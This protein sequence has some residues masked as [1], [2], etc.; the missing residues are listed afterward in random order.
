MQ[1]LLKSKIFI[2][3]IIFVLVLFSFISISS[4]S[5]ITYQDE[6][7]ELPEFL[8][9][10]YYFIY[11]KRISTSGDR[12]S[13]AY[14]YYISQVP[15][16]YKVYDDNRIQLIGEND[17]SNGKTYSI[18]GWDKT[19][20]ECI[21][22][23]SEPT[24]FSDSA[25][26]NK[27]HLDGQQSYVCNFDIKDAEGNVVFPKAPPQEEVPTV[28]LMKATQ[29][30]EIPQ[31]IVKIVMIVLPVFLAIFGTLLVLYLIKSKNLLHL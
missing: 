20:E 3:T 10:Y 8:D 29:V 14:G 26:W 28:E 27:S 22:E 21:S 2:A 18:S 31:Q 23:L 19:L 6:T 15:F 7:V 25:L 1:N 5:S 11:Y 13:Y 4:A 9:N 16:Y 17:I 24:H 30:E 12:F